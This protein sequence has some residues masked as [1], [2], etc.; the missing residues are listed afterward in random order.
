MR[1]IVKVL[2]I[3]LVIVSFFGVG[4]VFCQ[5]TPT[6][7]KTIPVTQGQEASSPNQS[8]DKN[9]SQEIL[10]KDSNNNVV[11]K[12]ITPVKGQKMSASEVGTKLILSGPV[13]S[14]EVK[15]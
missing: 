5:Q 10:V 4:V 3:G 7:Q 12:V 8:K 1:N 11:T 9:P 6:E 13:F 15:Y 2:I 14:T